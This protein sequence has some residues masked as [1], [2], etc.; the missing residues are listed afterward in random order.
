LEE[1]KINQVSED[2]KVHSRLLTKK[3][4][5]KKLRK[6]APEKYP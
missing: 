2:P 6:K 4:P 5:V 1:I 3:N